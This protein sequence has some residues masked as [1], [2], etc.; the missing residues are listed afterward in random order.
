M[1]KF[2]GEDEANSS[3]ARAQ[4]QKVQTGLFFALPSETVE[5]ISI[6]SVA[7]ILMK[8]FKADFANVI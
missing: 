3:L 2:G 5:N 8:V 7:C 1:A 6:V 4:L